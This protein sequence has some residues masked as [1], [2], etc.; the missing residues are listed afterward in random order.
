MDMWSKFV[1]GAMVIWSA[2]ASLAQGLRLGTPTYGGNGCPAGT[3]SVSVAPEENA[4]SILFD[5]FTTEAGRTTGRSIDRK[6]CNMTIPVTVPQGYS[7]ALF[8][9]DYRGYNAVPQGASNVFEVEYFWAGSRGPRISR[10][11]VGPQ[12]QNFIVTDNLVART[13]VWTPCGASVQLRVNANM[14]SQTNR[15]NEQ[16]IGTVD[17]ADFS[18]GMVY[19]VQWRRCQ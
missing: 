16:T 6:S 1:V 12:N 14:R 18:S 17:S 3:A 9:A 15:F 7:I 5:Q 4:V 13:L 10:T 8:Q 19:H 11:F 2:Q